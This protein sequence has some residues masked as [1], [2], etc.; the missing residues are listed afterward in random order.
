MKTYIFKIYGYVQGVGFRYYTFKKA[1]LLDIKGYVKNMSDGSVYVEAQG[2]EEKIKMFKEYLKK[3][4]IYSE[5]KEI[6]ENIV[7][8]NYK[9]KDFKIE[10]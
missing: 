4:P 10:V 8:S 2:D 3:G 7:E 6:K 5:V 9:F 1:N